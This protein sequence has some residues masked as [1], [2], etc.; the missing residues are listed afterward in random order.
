MV[1]GVSEIDSEKFNVQKF[2]A[3]V[4]VTQGSVTAP[5]TSWGQSLWF[6]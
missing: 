2:P 4:R 3:Q 5:P 1:E 6:L